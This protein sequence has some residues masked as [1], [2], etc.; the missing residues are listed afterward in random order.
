MLV[1]AIARRLAEHF[2][3]ISKSKSRKTFACVARLPSGAWLRDGQ[4]ATVVPKGIDPTIQESI[5]VYKGSNA[6]WLADW[7]STIKEHLR[8]VTQALSATRA[9]API[10][11]HVQRACND[12]VRC[13]CQ[14]KVE[15]RQVQTSIFASTTPPLQFINSAQLPTF[16]IVSSSL[17]KPS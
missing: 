2:T 13:R 10:T 3:K 15:F 1:T 14:C 4:P 8:L 7:S 16:G 11:H 12:I 6:W 9:E 5:A 17:Y